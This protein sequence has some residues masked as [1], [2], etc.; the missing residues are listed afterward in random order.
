MRNRVLSHDRLPELFLELF[1][2]IIL[3]LRRP[4]VF[5]ELLVRI[6][7]TLLP[8]FRLPAVLVLEISYLLPDQIAIQQSQPH[9]HSRLSGLLDY[10]E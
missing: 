9:L 10:Q 1:F 6:R 3:V 5:A 4:P 8:D 2:L 7:E